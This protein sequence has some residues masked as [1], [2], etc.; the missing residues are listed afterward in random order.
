M[1]GQNVFFINH[2]GGETPEGSS[3]NN[4]TNVIFDLNLANFLCQQGVQPGKI[5]IL[6]PYAAQKRQIEEDRSQ[7]SLDRVH[8]TTID[9]YQ[10]ILI[11]LS[12]HYI[13]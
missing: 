9:N 8:V 6:T 1:G 11:I 4:K 5:T 12:S 13:I 3:C 10:S 2:R 7:C